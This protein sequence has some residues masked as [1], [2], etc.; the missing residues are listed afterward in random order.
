M[1]LFI[2][3]KYFIIGVGFGA[4]FFI[5]LV[6]VLM[7]DR[8]TGM[9][10]CHIPLFSV[11]NDHVRIDFINESTENIQSIHVNGIISTGEIESG[12]RKVIMFPHN[13][14][15][16]YFFS[17]DFSSG[18]VLTENERYIEGGYFLTEHIYSDRVETDF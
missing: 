7:I 15:G 8:Y 12:E 18:K 1:N 14:E 17:V 16:T 9:L 5:A 2:V 11:R 13:G 4:G 6:L 10:E 3:K